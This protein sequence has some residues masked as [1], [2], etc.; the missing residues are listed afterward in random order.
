MGCA[1]RQDS[2]GL[3]LASGQVGTPADRPS[4][5]S[6]TT[7]LQLLGQKPGFCSPASWAGAATVHVNH[8]DAESRAAA[9][10]LALWVN[11]DLS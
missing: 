8:S 2:L 5:I 7:C 4:S 3:G 9:W 10:E 1:Q 11:E 6:R